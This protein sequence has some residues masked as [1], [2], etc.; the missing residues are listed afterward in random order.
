MQKLQSYTS[1]IKRVR[2][3]ALLF[4]A[5]Q[6][7][8]A[9]QE[10]H[11]IDLAAIQELSQQEEI[12]VGLVLSGGGAK[13]LAHIGAIRVLEEAGVQI[14]YIGGTSMGAIIGGLHAVGYSADQ[15]DSIFQVTDFNKLIRDEL[16]REAKTFFEREQSDKYA[17]SLPF[18][19]YK[20][21]TPSGLS[22]G[23]NVFN[24]LARL[25]QH[26]Q[27]EDF[28]KFPI[29]FFCIATNLET[30]EEVIMDKGSL[31]L[32]M[33]IS[34]AIPTVFR[35]IEYQWQLH[36]DGGVVN[37][38][39]VEELKRRGANFIIG[40]DVQEDL[41]G[42]ERL[43][44]GFEV[45]AQISNFRTIK[46]MRKKRNLTD[47]Y[48]RPDI[49]EYSVLDFDKGT[50]LIE[51]GTIAAKLHFESLVRLGNAQQ[52]NQPV[53]QIPFWKP[54]ASDSIK[55]QDIY[56]S[57]N[58]NY[59]RNYILGKL[60][61]KGKEKISFKDLNN[62]LNNLSSTGNFDRI[63]YT[64]TFNDDGSRD[65]HFKVF[66]TQQKKFL[67]FALHYDDLYK[68]AVLINYTQ[69]NLLF[70]NDLLAVD[71]IAGDNMRYNAS[72]Y[73]DKGRYW[74]V[75][76]NSRFNRFATDVDASL[77]NQITGILDPSENINQLRLVNNDFTNQ[78]F[79]E[80]FF[81][82]KLRFGTGLEQKFLEATTQTFIDT[83]NDG[84]GEKQTT[85]ETSNLIS[86]YGYLE[87]DSMDHSFYPTKG[88]FFRGDMN[89]Y[90]AS[91]ATNKTI[92]SFSIAKGRMAYAQ[93]LGNRVS[94]K[95]HS[96]LGFRIGAEDMSGLNF[97][98]GGFGNYAINNFR[99]FYGYDF[100]SLSAD[101]YISGGFDLFYNFYGPNYFIASANFA[102]V[103]NSIL[104]SG[105]WLS[106][107]KF[108]GYALGY[109]LDTFL[110]PMDVKA[111]YSPEVKDIIWYVS[112]G[113]R[114]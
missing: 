11:E 36:T 58:Q 54:S 102:N 24:F 109:G 100:L 64:T 78:F 71:L 108:S 50:Q 23:Q 55:I 8:Y 13:G 59:K 106:W 27:E 38:Y 82:N 16:P 37:N 77:V 51:N 79:I 32:A 26:A 75:G 57:G 52:K 103:E 91:I 74:S 94:L 7:G 61:L 39:P 22:K 15:M 3:F 87:F 96:E 53:K 9:Q 80:T 18:D 89:I 114:F 76:I 97:F 81:W 20:I 10:L 41:H 92:S 99:P 56:I 60:K 107:P 111:S 113:Y 17:L 43:V 104:T 40:V 19:G 44:T 12:K 34:G 65:L 66:E 45:M 68:S 95:L 49:D 70:K 47:I 5:F 110:G 21:K 69:K 98:L 4:W 83:D 35:P 88:F 48:I 101:S 25:T 31:A 42:R 112:L 86:N 67:R 62:G 14:D 93:K 105:D 85:I 90:W 46:A 29:P 28:T 33:S 72:Y 30:G 63:N 6:L 1:T 2:L 73:I 84:N